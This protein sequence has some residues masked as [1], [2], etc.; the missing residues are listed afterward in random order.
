MFIGRPPIRLP[1]NLTIAHVKRDRQFP[2]QAGPCHGHC[3]SSYMLSSYR[4]RY[5]PAAIRCLY[6][7]AHLAARQRCLD[8]RPPCNSV[9]DLR[10]AL[11]PYRFPDA[12]TPEEADVNCDASQDVEPYVPHR[13]PDPNNPRFAQK[14]YN[15]PADA[16]DRLVDVYA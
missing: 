13:I 12:R 14:S 15:P 8:F 16:I 3:E 9:D 11:W 6:T 10:P 5:V 1:G 4:R 2:V 7:E